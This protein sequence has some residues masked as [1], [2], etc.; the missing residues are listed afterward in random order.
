MANS[1]QWQQTFLKWPASIQRRGILTTVLN[2]HIPFKGFMT[3]D[4]L[5]LLERQNPDSLGARFV[6]LEYEVINSMRYIDP[7]K[8]ENFAELGFVGKLS[9]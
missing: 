3:T 8:A 1:A 5:L 6:V 9:Q 2:E 4:S 7:L